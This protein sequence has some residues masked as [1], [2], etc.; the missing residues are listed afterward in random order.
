MRHK[1]GCAFAY[2]LYNLVRLI[3]FKL[4]TDEMR[5]RLKA[6]KDRIFI[7]KTAIVAVNPDLCAQRLGLNLECLSDGGIDRRHQ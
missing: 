3:A 7:G 6:V 5:T 1:L 4:Q 2:G